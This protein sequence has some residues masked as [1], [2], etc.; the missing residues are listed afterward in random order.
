MRS[1]EG[2]YLNF[3]GNPVQKAT[4][5]NVQKQNHPVAQQQLYPVVRGRTRSLQGAI[6]LLTERSAAAGDGQPK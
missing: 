2:V 1:W 5:P 6:W 4:L 3:L